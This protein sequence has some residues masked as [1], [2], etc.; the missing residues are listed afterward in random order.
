[1]LPHLDA[2]IIKNFYAK[3]EKS[4]TNAY[5]YIRSPY[6]IGYIFNNLLLLSNFVYGTDE[7]YINP[8][9]LQWY[10]VY[11]WEWKQGYVGMMY[12]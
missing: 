12:N 5:I 9:Y 2:I 1:M 6:G 8:L 11:L 3:L 4:Q 10:T 7:I